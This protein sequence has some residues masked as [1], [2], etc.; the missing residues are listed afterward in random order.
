MGPLPSWSLGQGQW[1]DEGRWEGLSARELVKAGQLAGDGQ[2]STWLEDSQLRDDAETRGLSS[3]QSPEVC[4]S[5][6]LLAIPEHVS[7]CL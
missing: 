1:A 2:E 6:W 5:A 7:L 4:V 3:E